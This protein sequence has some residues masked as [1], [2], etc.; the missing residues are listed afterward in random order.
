IIITEEDSTKEPEVS[1]DKSV[2]PMTWSPHHCLEELFEPRSFTAINGNIKDLGHVP[3]AKTYR[4][5]CGDKLID[6]YA[7]PHEETRTLAEKIPDVEF[8]FVYRLPE[9]ARRALALRPEARKIEDWHPFRVVPPRITR[10]K[11]S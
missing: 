6:G 10:L 7:V 8:A 2:F 1:Y 3:T 9:S 11:G 4:V 5:R